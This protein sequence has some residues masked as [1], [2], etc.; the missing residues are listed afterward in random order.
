VQLYWVSASHTGRYARLTSLGLYVMYVLL[1]ALLSDTVRFSIIYCPRHWM[2][3]SGR[4]FLYSIYALILD[5]INIITMLHSRT[6][7]SLRNFATLCIRLVRPS[8]QRRCSGFGHRSRLISH[9]S[10]A[11]SLASQSLTPCRVSTSYPS[12]AKIRN[13]TIAILVDR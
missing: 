8:R 9:S 12:A 2:A 4:S 1:R 6:L 5:T 11:G 3:S 7:M 13:D 10:P